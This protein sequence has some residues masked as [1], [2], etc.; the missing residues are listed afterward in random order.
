MNVGVRSSALRR[1]RSAFSLVELLVVIAIIALL[2]AIVLPALS[3]AREQAR[4]AVCLSNLRQLGASF[5]MYAADYDDRCLP[6]AYWSFDIIGTGP[7]VYWWGTNESAGVDHTRGFVWPYLQ[8]SPGERSVFECPVQPAHTYRRQGAAGALTSTYGYNG[9]YLSPPHTPG[10][11]FQIGH[12][13]WRSLTQVRDTATVF[14]FADTLIDQGG[15][16]PFNNALLDPPMLYSNGA[17]S[18][19]TRP[20]TAFRHAGG[21][22]TVHVDGHASRYVAEAASFTSPRFGIG[23]VGVEN[24]PHYVPDWRDW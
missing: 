6:L 1:E 17:W 15:S 16:Q 2:V 8:S 23:S 20:T 11:G 10:W 5:S 13:P 9:Y 4:G 14:A 24:G 18:A 3:S 12:R 7:V 19:N 22:Q 21:T